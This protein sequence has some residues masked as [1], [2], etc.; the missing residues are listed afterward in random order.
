[1]KAQPPPALLLVKLPDQRQQA[2]LGRIDIAA[3][4]G[5]FGAKTLAFFARGCF[6]R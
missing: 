6:S 2:V 4:F 5:D 1:M 3:K